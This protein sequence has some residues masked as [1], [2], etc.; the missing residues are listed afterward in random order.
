MPKQ[1][2]RPLG[3]GVVLLGGERPVPTETPKLPQPEPTKARH[4]P[5]GSFLAV[6]A[7]KERRMVSTISEA[8]HV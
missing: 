4:P 3:D 2:R 1:E 6:T 7:D 8:R 5:L